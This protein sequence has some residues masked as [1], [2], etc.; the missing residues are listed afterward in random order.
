ML[1]GNIILVVLIWK[2]HFEVKY[3]LDGKFD[4]DGMYGMYLFWEETLKNSWIIAVTSRL[5]KL[6][7]LQ[8]STG[9]RDLWGPELRLSAFAPNAVEPP[10]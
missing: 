8:I 1:R 3:H 2:F 5:N 10:S 9:M 4:F 6:E 7:A